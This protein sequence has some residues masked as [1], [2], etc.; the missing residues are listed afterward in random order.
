VGSV[1]QTL[2]FF[3]DCLDPSYKCR[4][5]KLSP[6][7]LVRAIGEEGDPPIANERDELPVVGGPDVRTKVLGFMN[8]SLPLHID[9]DEVI[10]SG[11][12][13]R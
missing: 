7:D 8:A 12:E 4:R 1:S 6:N 10:G 5:V 11:L 13:H 9:E 3:E 2:V